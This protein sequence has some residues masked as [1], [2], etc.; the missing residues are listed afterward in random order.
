MGYAIQN[1]PHQPD[2]SAPLSRQFQADITY[3]PNVILSS[4]VITYDI[5][6]KLT[7]CF[8]LLWSRVP[9][10]RRGGSGFGALRGSVLPERYRRYQRALSAAG[11]S[12]VPVQ[13][14]PPAEISLINLRSCEE[15]AR[16]TATRS[17][18]VLLGS[19]IAIAPSPKGLD[20]R[21]NWPESITRKRRFA[22]IAM[23]LCGSCRHRPCRSGSGP[24]PGGVHRQSRPPYGSN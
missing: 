17:T 20:D 3:Y 23:T 11:S 2:R 12:T 10:S 9:V 22:V 15:D 21:C 4:N 6:G 24:S 18:H 14:S 7:C 1:A 8:R 19:A 13:R 5:S 16:A